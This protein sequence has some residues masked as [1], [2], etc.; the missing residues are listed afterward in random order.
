MN[1]QPNR[2]RNWMALAATLLLAWRAFNPASSLAVGSWT[3]V[4]NLL[5]LRPGRSAK[6]FVLLGAG[7][8]IGSAE[9]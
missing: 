6:V 9:L 4:F 5:D 8:L 1:P 2:C 3:N 7:L